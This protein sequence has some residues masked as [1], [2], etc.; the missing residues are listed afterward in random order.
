M[1]TRAVYQPE[2]QTLTNPSQGTTNAGEQQ[3]PLFQAS[4]S[5]RYERQE[6]IREYEA[7]LGCRLIVFIDAIF[8][9]SVTVFEDLIYDADPTQDLHLLLASPGGDGETAV[10][11][12]RSAQSRCRELTV[13]VPDIAKSAATLLAMGAH[14]ILMGPSS[15]LGP[16]DP[17]FYLNG[18]LVAAKD[19]IAT[20]DDATQRVQEA[21]DTYP[22]YASLLSNLTALITQQARSALDRSED[23]LLEALQSNP[24]RDECLVETLRDQLKEPLITRPRTHAALFGMKDAKDAGLPVLEADLHGSQWKMI[25]QLWAK[26]YNLRAG[27]WTRI[28]ESKN[29][30]WVSQ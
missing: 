22:L 16:I 9:P 12:V 1:P 13:I 18:E 15:D 19:I 11:L 26:Y 21:P 25:W 4:Q 27:G 24:D 28:Y 7:Q 17:Q 8:P 29:S 10:R 3:A 14:H 5:A 2:N 6:V 30:S 20:V 23:L